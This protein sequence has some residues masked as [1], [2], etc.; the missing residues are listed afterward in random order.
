MLDGLLHGHLPTLE[1]SDLTKHLMLVEYANEFDYCAETLAPPLFDIL[2]AVFFGVMTS[3]AY[4]LAVGLPPRSRVGPSE[5]PC[6]Q[7]SP[8]ERTR[9]TRRSARRVGGQL[10]A[11]GP[12]ALHQE[13]LRGCLECQAVVGS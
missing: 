4:H 11:D 5:V 9:R 10:P 12:V 1:H 7:R 6:Q 13:F 2:S 3:L 8:P